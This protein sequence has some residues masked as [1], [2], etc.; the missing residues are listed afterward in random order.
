MR[1]LFVAATAALLS[2]AIVAAPASAKP[3]Y[4]AA[5]FD[6]VATIDC[7]WGPFTVGS[8]VDTASP[9]VELYTGIELLPV[10]WKLQIGE[11]TYHELIPNRYR[12]V[13]LTCSY[14][15]GVATGKVKVV[16]KL[17]QF[18]DRLRAA[19]GRGRDA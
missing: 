9:F 17:D 5:D 18:L 16:V 2:L 3:K 6:Y 14:D 19:R 1:K 8:G 4:T 12:G 13:R 15:D 7:G 11:D 10:E